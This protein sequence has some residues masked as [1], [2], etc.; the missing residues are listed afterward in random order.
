VSRSV[1]VCRG[2][3]KLSSLTLDRPAHGVRGVSVEVCR[4]PLSSSCRAILSSSLSSSCRVSCRVVEG[5]ARAQGA[6]RDGD[7]VC[8]TSYVYVSFCK[9]LVFDT[10]PGGPSACRV[11]VTRRPAPRIGRPGVDGVPHT[12]A[13]RNNGSLHSHSG[14]VG[15]GVNHRMYNTMYLEREAPR[16]SQRPTRSKRLEVKQIHHGR[17]EG[18]QF[19]HLLL[20]LKQVVL[21]LFDAAVRILD[22]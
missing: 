21:D 13:T 19:Q 20:R 16:V 17:D 7:R 2:L 8:S 10:G 9:A 1:E 6:R 12:G 11:L 4:G 18:P 3:S 14:I 22:A 5:E 15:G